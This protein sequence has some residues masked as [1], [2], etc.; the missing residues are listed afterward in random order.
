M[1]EDKKFDVRLIKR[2]LESGRITEDELKKTLDAL[3]DCTD[4]FETVSTR[5]PIAGK[6][7]QDEQ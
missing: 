7:S 2:H 6:D 1:N 3:P 5:Q 4:K